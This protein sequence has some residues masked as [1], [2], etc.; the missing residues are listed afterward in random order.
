MVCKPDDPGAL[1]W[2]VTVGLTNCTLKNLGN[3]LARLED[4][5]R[6]AFHAG[7][8]DTTVALREKLGL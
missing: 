7:V 6:H 4:F 3:F 8:D 2:Y 5:L 1:D